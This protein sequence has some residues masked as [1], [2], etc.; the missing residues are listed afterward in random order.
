MDADGET[1]EITLLST[2]SLATYAFD[3]GAM[4]GA[5][6]DQHRVTE[7]F[8]FTAPEDGQVLVYWKPVRTGTVRRYSYVNIRWEW[9]GVISE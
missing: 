4:Q 2:D 7:T 8:N 6:N 1:T 5:L 3:E 9:L